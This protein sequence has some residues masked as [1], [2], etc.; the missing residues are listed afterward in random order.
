[1]GKVGDP[2]GIANLKRLHLFDTRYDG[3]DIGSFTQRAFDF[4]VVAMADKHQ[5]VS[6]LGELDGFDVNLG[7]QRTSGVNHLELALLGAVA[8]GRRDAVRAVDH[9]H[10]GRHLVDIVDEDRALFR[11]LIYNEAVMDDFFANVDGR[12][13]GFERNLHDVNGANNA[14]AEAARLEQK[15]TLFDG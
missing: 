12:A 6:L 3:R 9:T 7:D 4:V 10:P 1:M 2:V 14:R 13:E 8:Y 11:Q 5:R 15:D